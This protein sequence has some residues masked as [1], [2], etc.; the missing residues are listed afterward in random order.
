MGV[1]TF[2]MFKIDTEGP[3]ESKVR[4]EESIFSCEDR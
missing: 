1:V 3:I 4:R 2:N